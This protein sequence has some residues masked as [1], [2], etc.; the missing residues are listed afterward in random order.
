MRREILGVRREIQGSEG[1][2]LLE[3]RSRKF[4]LQV[5]WVRNSKQMLMWS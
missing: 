3:P 2:L 4:R 1:P 5:R